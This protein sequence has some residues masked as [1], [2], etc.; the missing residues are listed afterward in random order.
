MKRLRKTAALLLSAVLLYSGCRGT[1]SEKENKPG[2]NMSG[3][4][5]VDD[6]PE[7]TGNTQFLTHVY[8]SAGELV[9]AGSTVSA[10]GV[11]YDA[12]TGTLMC[13]LSDSGTNDRFAE[14]RED[15]GVVREIP[16]PEGIYPWFY[17]VSEDRIW[18]CYQVADE[19]AFNTYDVSVYLNAVDLADGSPLAGEDG[20][21]LSE[22]FEEDWAEYVS[23]QDLAVDADGDLV[24]LTDLQIGIFS[25]DFTLKRIVDF[26]KNSP[27]LITAPDGTVWVEY[28][29]SKGKNVAAPFD[30][31]SG[32]T[33]GER[34]LAG[35]ISGFGCRE[36]FFTDAG[37]PV[38]R[39]DVGVW[40]LR[41]NEDGESVPQL[42]MDWK[43]SSV[44][45]GSATLCGAPSTDL[46]L[47]M[48]GIYS[49]EGSLALWKS[50]EDI[51]L[52]RIRVIEL[53]STV[54]MPDYLASA[55]VEFNK[56]HPDTRIAVKD[57]YNDF[58]WDNDFAYVASKLIQDILT[59]TY[60]PDIVVSRS[61]REDLGYFREHCMTLDLGPYLDRDDTVNRE[62]VFG[63]LQRVYGTEDGGMWAIPDEFTVRTL[64][65]PASAWNGGDNGWTL[66]EMLDYI[67]ALPADMILM[68]GLTKENAASRLLGQNGY[69]AFF[70]R[71]SGIC[72]FDD[73][74]YLRW[75]NFLLALPANET[76]LKKSSEFESKSTAERYEYYWRGQVALSSFTIM[77]YDSILEPTFQFGTRDWTFAGYPSESGIPGA[78]IESREAVFAIMNWAEEKDEAWELIRSV[79][80]EPTGWEHHRFGLSVLKSNIRKELDRAEDYVYSFTFD[81]MRRSTAKSLFE[82]PPTDAD[83]DRPGKIVEFSPEDS[84]RLMRF[85][86]NIAGESAAKDMPDEVRG[87]ID[88]EVSVLF[89]GVGTAENCAAKIQ[90]RASIWM[91]EN[92]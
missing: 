47:I 81:G 15:A 51:D 39:D 11:R 88:E 24:V 73:P 36:F 38:W 2:G 76:E 66:S 80:S 3:V 43:N 44:D 29:N 48:E 10:N 62:T 45:S 5:T 14:I 26:S 50:S 72:S 6:L 33:G 21:L 52:A 85:L 67:E 25:P 61:G 8:K 78:E 49:G 27:E 37:E 20:I 60:R 34:V 83:L 22:V 68:Q 90:S 71:E 12:E 64:I 30:K 89:G 70:D 13:V 77:D 18:Y 32:K 79:V 23:V 75:L 35:G 65:A 16:F 41:E 19:V 58:Y 53:A 42:L 84:E 9:P 63:C 17:A 31:D 55:I 86:D 57:Y 1:G 40:V 56:T 74:L 87:I 69:G 7:N 54:Q 46:L 28:M 91:A 82:H 4:I 59:G 92:R